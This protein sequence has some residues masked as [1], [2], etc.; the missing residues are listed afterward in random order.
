M[1]SK[2]PDGT[3]MEWLELV[4]DA[5]YDYAELPMAQMAALDA[6]TLRRLAKKLETLGLP[7]EVCNNF[8]PAKVRITGYT[9]EYAMVRDYVKRALEIADMLGVK[10]I[11]VGSVGARN[12]PE[13]FSYEKGIAQL[14]DFFLRLSDMLPN[15]LTAVIEPVCRLETNLLFTL[16]EGIALM[17]AVDRENIRVLA[18]YYHMANL[19]EPVTNIL[20]AGNDLWH[21][22]FS[23]IEGRKTP[24]VLDPGMQAFWDA[25]EQIDYVHRMSIESFTDDPY[26]DLPKARRLFN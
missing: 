8:L 7:C 9:V 15:G 24:V 23:A 4:R 19:E 3:G 2:A 14:K 25:L 26:V 6:Q 1:L 13:G 11:V 18:D 22:H 21:A 20:E 17:R 5:G 12:I 10:I 16:K